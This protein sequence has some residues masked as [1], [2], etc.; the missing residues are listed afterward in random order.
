MAESDY[1]EEDVQDNEDDNTVPTPT[2]MPSFRRG[3][4]KP[5][6]AYIMEDHARGE[7]TYTKFLQYIRIGAFAW[8]AAEALGI[9]PDAF[10]RWLRWGKESKK[11]GNGI[12]R[13]F[14]EDVTQ[15]QAQAR[16]M[17]EVKVAQED[18]KYYLRIGPGRTRV[19]DDMTLPGWT[20]EPQ[21]IVID[22]HVSGEIQHTHQLRADVDIP[23][24]AEALSTLANAN[25][26]AL[27]DKGKQLS[28]APPTPD[29]ED[30]I[31]VDYEDVPDSAEDDLPPEDG[32]EDD[33]D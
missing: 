2:G 15:A 21:H 20:E 3:G 16:L 11:K 12:Y 1:D 17:A 19:L 14:Y 28:S 23:T 29:E 25:L 27:T 7:T 26:I 22:S 8:V 18:P 33:L 10:Y 13:K 6:L 4:R 30:A 32:T 9:S 31:D 5:K 24:I